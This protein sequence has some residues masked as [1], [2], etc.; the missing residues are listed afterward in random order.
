MDKHQVKES[1]QFIFEENKVIDEYSTKRVLARMS[2]PSPKRKKR[3]SFTPAIVTILLLFGTGILAAT[4]LPNEKQNAVTVDNNE[5]ENTGVEEMGSSKSVGELELELSFAQDKLEHYQSVIDQML[6]SLTDEE[7]LQLAKSQ[8]TY[9]LMINNIPIPSNGR[10]EVE[11]G[12][13]NLLLTYRIPPVYVLPDE[14]IQKGHNDF[15]SGDFFKHIQNIEPGGGEE[16]YADGVN[17]TG[18]GYK[19]TNVKSGEKITFTVTDELKESLELE[20]NEIEITIK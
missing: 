14:W 11:K 10:L 9:E 17:I 7:K 16:V 2:Q 20:T 12:E 1:I 13:V 4:M 8:F 18:R 3:M 15:I 5:V 6:P 19:Y